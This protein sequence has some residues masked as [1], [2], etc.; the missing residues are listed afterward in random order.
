MNA[1]TSG[2]V[3]GGVPASEPMATPIGAKAATIRRPGNGAT[4]VSAATAAHTSGDR[5][6]E[7]DE[8]EQH[9]RRERGETA[10]LHGLEGTDHGACVA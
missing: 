10:P 9:D 5:A 1:S 6:R 4:A 7:S 2:S 3:H 8:G